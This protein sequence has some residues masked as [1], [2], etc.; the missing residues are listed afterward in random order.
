MDIY[1]IV[2]NTILITLVVYLLV[3]K[4]KQVATPPTNDQNKQNNL[5]KTE[6]DNN[7]L[8][9]LH[10]PAIRINLD[11]LI[12]EY[13]YMA[14]DLIPNIEIGKTSEPD[15]IISSYEPQLPFKEA[16]IKRKVITKKLLLASRQYEMKVIPIYHHSNIDGFYEIFTDI[17]ELEELRKSKEQRSKLETIGHLSMGMA[18]DF[19]NILQVI[20]GNAELCLDYGE[21]N[22]VYVENIETII[23]AANKASSL[24]KQL[25]IFT[26]KQEVEFVDLNVNES[27][28]YMRKM[29]SRLIGE[30]INI[31]LKLSSSPIKIKADEIQFEQIILNLCLNARDAMENGGTIKISTE[32]IEIKADDFKDNFD[33]RPGKYLKLSV[34]DT[35]VGIS[36]EHI[37]KIFEPF[38]TTKAEGKGTGLGLSNVQGIVKQYNG[39]IDIESNIGFG[40]VFKI[41][42]P[43]H[44]ANVINSI[45]QLAKSKTRI[46]GKKEK[47]LLI[48]DDDLICNVVLKIL[49]KNNFTVVACRD[50]ASASEIIKEQFN[51]IDLIISDL[52]LPDGDGYS[53]YESLKSI[54]SQ[55]PFIITSGYS[56]EKDELKKLISQGILFLRKPFSSEDLLNAV[57]KT[58]KKEN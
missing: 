20:I 43:I 37:E 2:I 9:R 44:Q 53:L 46:I 13:N 28:S 56:K 17:S 18:H 7:L 24:T 3:S 41:Y 34:A 33:R 48:E 40:T 21:S 23:Q 57:S 8:F 30:N 31:D 14:R 4:N 58:L 35:G 19:N 52:I 36:Q 5:L 51:N 16:F 32:E 47:V 38:F 1:L 49:R 50:I 22:E 12:E 26:R 45:A 55:V 15:L 6:T 42:L 10:L 29:I 25:L 54:H 39:F 27:L 11:G